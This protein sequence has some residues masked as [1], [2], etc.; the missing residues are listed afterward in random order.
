MISHL[1]QII[2]RSPGDVLADMVGVASIF[3]ILIVGL[4][5][6]ALG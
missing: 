3:V 1:K 2:L 5:L 6:T 4:N